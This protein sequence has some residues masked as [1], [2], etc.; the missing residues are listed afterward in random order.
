MKK[1]LLILLS[2]VSLFY[3]SAQSTVNYAFTTNTNGSLAQDVNANTVDMTTGTTQ[4]I[5]PNVNSTASGLTNIG[6]DFWFM[7][8]RHTTFNV[9]SHGLLGLTTAITT[10][11]NIGTG[12]GARIGAFVNGITGTN[13]ATSATGKVHFK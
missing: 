2:M 7:G 4:L 13:M 3:A 6:F 1:I 10:G 12:I 11:N 8:V 9:S 5:G